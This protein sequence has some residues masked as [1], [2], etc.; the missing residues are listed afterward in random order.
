MI[1]RGLRA[2][3][4]VALLVLCALTLALAGPV[5]VPAL[6]GDAPFC[7]RSGRCCCDSRNN[8]PNALHLKTTCRCARPDGTAVVFALPLGL[9]RPGPTLS[10]PTPAGPLASRPVPIPREGDLSPPDEP[11]RLSRIT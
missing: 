8:S 5:L 10:D 3:Q 11:P 2:R 7:C 9:L 4:G 6:G 1:A